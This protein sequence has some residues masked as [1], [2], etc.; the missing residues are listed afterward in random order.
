MKNVT[1]FVGLIVAIQLGAQAGQSLFEDRF[2][3]GPP[4][5]HWRSHWADLK[6]LDG[7]LRIGQA[8][9]ASHGAVLDTLVDFSDIE[10]AFRLRFDGA[11]QLNVVM[12]DRNHKGSHAGHIC[13]VILRSDSVLLGDDKTGI[14]ENRIFAMR[15]D[16]EKKEE[17]EGL[18]T[19]K[20]KRIPVQ[21]TTGEWHSVKV[22]IRGDVLAVTLNGQVVGSLRS[23]GI[24]H[25]TKTDFGF[26]VP[27]R[28]VLID[29]VVA[30]LPLAKGAETVR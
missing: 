3:A 16:P 17:A 22:S 1:L 10:I 23:A 29:D 2:D 30:T 8:K 13:R 26:T 18:L 27:G 15:R 6:V 24:G 14:M 12:D 25:G 7:A 20:S 11:K 21:L 5:A 28:F 4:A 19:G 9:D